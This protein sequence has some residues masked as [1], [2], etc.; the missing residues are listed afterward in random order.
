MGLFCTIAARSQTRFSV[1]LRPQISWFKSD[2]KAT[3]PDGA[4]TGL[5]FGLNMEKYFT[6]NYSL[7]T[8]IYLNNT[9]GF[10]KYDS[11]ASQ[12]Q[13]F[14]ID[15]DTVDLPAGSALEYHL[16]YFDIPVLVKFRTEAF[17]DVRYHA[18]LGGVAQLR[19]SATA[20][21]NNLIYIEDENIVE[22]MRP[23]AAAYCI[24]AGIEYLLGQST[25]LDLGFLYT[26]G[27]ADLTSNN[28]GREK[29]IV[30]LRIF[31]LRA[32]VIF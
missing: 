20:E 24:G 1:E 5:N 29:D 27:F 30:S 25:T 14:L 6:E 4:K 8:G 15:G 22:E 2:S 21:A 26:G 10:L 12:T 32:A 18:R 7:V 9:G 28:A 19:L 13:P 31:A 23:F 16:Q 17:G 11:G 3:K